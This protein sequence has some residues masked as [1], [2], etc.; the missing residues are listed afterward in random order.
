MLDILGEISS[1]PPWLYRGW[2]YLF[3]KTYR[4]DVKLEYKKMSPLLRPFD[5]IF[6]FSFFIGELGAIFYSLYWLVNN[7]V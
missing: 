1:A 7:A 6:S 4:S 2:A 5:F 3:S